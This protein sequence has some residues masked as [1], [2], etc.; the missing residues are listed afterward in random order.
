MFKEESMRTCV[1]CNQEKSIIN[2][3]VKEFPVDILKSQTKVLVI[4]VVILVVSFFFAKEPYQYIVSGIL[5]GLTM[6]QI[7]LL[8]IAAAYLEN[9]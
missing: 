4:V 3:L 8:R 1:V 2:N 9:K 6:L 5:T 7:T